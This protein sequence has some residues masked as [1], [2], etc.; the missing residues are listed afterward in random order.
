VTS[1]LFCSQF[2]EKLFCYSDALAATGFP[3]KVHISQYLASGHL[4]WVQFPHCDFFLYRSTYTKNHF[5]FKTYFYP[6][7]WI[8]PRFVHLGSVHLLLLVRVRSTTMHLCFWVQPIP[9]FL[10][11]VPSTHTFINWLRFNTLHPDSVHQHFIQ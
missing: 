7:T 1:S 8:R 3:F 10:Y 4:H 5:T 2:L 6:C 9:T 11:L